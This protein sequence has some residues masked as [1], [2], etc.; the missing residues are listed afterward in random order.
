MS[1]PPAIRAA[2]PE[3]SRVATSPVGISVLSPAQSSTSGRW[4]NSQPPNL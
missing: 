1:Q 2:V 3:I 4:V